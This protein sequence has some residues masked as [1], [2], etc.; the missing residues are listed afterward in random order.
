MVL[1]YKLAVRLAEKLGDAVPGDFPMATRFVNSG[2]E[3]IL[4]ERGCI[5]P[6][7]EYFPKIEAI[8]EEFGIL[9]IADE[10]Q[11]GIGRTGTMFA[12]EHGGV[13]ADLTTVA[14]SLAAGMPLS[15]V[16]GCK[17]LMNTVHAGGI[18]GTHGGNPVPVRRPRPC[19]NTASSAAW[20]CWPAA[21]KAM[22]SVC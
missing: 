21:V 18:G 13:D 16:V 2:A 12:M 6:P 19:S 5:T 10:I 4:G 7:V 11:T 22:S 3:P 1:P 20:S 8:C 14:K 17:E 15:A 9:F